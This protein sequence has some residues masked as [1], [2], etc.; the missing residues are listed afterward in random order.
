MM[1][2]IIEVGREFA[3]HQTKRRVMARALIVSPKT[4]NDHE[5]FGIQA[6]P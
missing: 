6:D 1:V 4:Q 2:E 3:S 5:R